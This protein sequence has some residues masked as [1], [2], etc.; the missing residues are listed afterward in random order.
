MG[1][2]IVGGRKGCDENGWGWKRFGAGEWLEVKMMEG[3]KKVGVK[4]LGVKNG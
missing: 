1:V 2:K 3:E 4:T